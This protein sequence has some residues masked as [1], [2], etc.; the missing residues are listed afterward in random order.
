MIE[1]VDLDTMEVCSH[2]FLQSKHQTYKSVDF[3]ADELAPM[4][5][6]QLDESATGD[7]RTGNAVLVD[8]VHYREYRPFNATELAGQATQTRR[9][10]KLTGVLFEGIMCSATKEDM[11]GLASIRPYVMAGNDTKFQFD[12][13]STLTLTLANYAAFEAVWTPFRAGFFL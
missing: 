1:Y 10:D 11:W 4:N 12:N 7:R 13:G 2:G 6:A 3:T 5:A 9:A 8:G